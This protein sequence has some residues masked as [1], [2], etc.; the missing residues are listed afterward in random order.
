MIY[1]ISLLYIISVVSMVISIFLIRNALIRLD[2]AIR[3][4]EETQAFWYE[5]A[6]RIYS[7]HAFSSQFYDFDLQKVHIDILLDANMYLTSL[8]TNVDLKDRK[9]IH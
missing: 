9:F 1:L 7:L 4:M 5:T 2:G 8:H 3:T 6:S